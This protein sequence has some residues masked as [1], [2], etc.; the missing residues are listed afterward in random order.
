ME[1][2]FVVGQVNGVC[3][4]YITLRLMIDSDGRGTVA[5]MGQAALLMRADH[6]EQFK[7]LVTQCDETI[8]RLKKSGELKYV[9]EGFELRT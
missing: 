5:M 9:V 8:E 6:W 1:A 7:A 4:G 2:S 3:G